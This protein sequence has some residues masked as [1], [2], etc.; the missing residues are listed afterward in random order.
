VGLPDYKSNPHPG[1]ISTSTRSF[2]AH[3]KQKLGLGKYQSKTP[4][5]TNST[6]RGVS[7]LDTDDGDEEE[8]DDEYMKVIIL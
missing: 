1:F 7:G 8:E 3:V 4:F 5:S 6:L 2:D